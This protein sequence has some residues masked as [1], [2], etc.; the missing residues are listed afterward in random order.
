[1]NKKY[2]QAKEI[3]G[4]FTV[5][6]SPEY[7]AEKAEYFSEYILEKNSRAF[8]WE[9]DGKGKIRIE[10]CFFCF[11]NTYFKDSAGSMMV[12]KQIHKK[13]ETAIRSGKM[14]KESI[15]FKINIY[16]K[17][18]VN[19]S[20][21]SYFHVKGKKENSGFMHGVAYFLDSGDEEKAETGEIDIKIHDIKNQMMML[22]A[23]A[24]N[25]QN[26]TRNLKIKRNTRYIK[27][28]IY[29]CGNMLSLLY[30]NQNNEMKAEPTEELFN[31]HSI[32][33]ASVESFCGEKNI[34]FI[35]S[36]NAHNPIIYADRSLIQNSIHNVVLNAVQAC[37]ARGKIKIRTFNA[38]KTFADNVCIKISDNGKGIKKEVL[39]KIFEKDFTTKERGKGL[40]LYSAKQAIEKIGGEISAEAKKGRGSTFTICLRCHV[41]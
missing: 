10:H 19:V 26:E 38:E 29:S 17:S 22:L 20:K 16:K 18:S 28:T 27:E 31:I 21:T 1:M 7:S 8:F 13:I 5:F 12:D 33:N 15:D 30:Q 23:Y 4:F 39:S 34:K 24:E 6:S 25:I 35:C 41:E 3:L 2:I 37:E 40:G 32:I 9:T 14:N 36:L 11:I